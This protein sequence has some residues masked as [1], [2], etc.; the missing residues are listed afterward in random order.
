MANLEIH[1]FLHRAQ[2]LERPTAA[3]FDLDPGEGASILD[4]ADVAFRLKAAMEKA[5]LQCFPKVS[6]SKGM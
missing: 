1:P 4:C 6:G 3:A 5:G 2:D